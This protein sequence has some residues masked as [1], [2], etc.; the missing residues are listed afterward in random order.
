MRVDSATKR[1]KPRDTV[2]PTSPTGVDVSTPAW[3]ESDGNVL[4][5]K[6]TMGFIAIGSTSDIFRLS[7]AFAEVLNE[8]PRVRVLY[9][10]TS[11]GRLWVVDGKPDG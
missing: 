10:R 6:L 2:E 8:Y 4:E 9:S 11:L 3:P 5:P 7:K 1:K